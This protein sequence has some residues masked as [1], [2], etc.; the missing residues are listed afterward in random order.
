MFDGRVLKIKEDIILKWRLLVE[1]GR[2]TGHTF[3]QPDL[4]IAA[5]AIHHGLTVVTR[6]RS[7][8]DKAHVPVM[9]P[10]DAQ[11]DATAFPF[12]C[13]LAEPSYR[14]RHQSVKSWGCGGKAPAG[15]ASDP[16]FLLKYG[17]PLIMHN[18]DFLCSLAGR[19]QLSG[20][21]LPSPSAQRCYPA[22]HRQH[23]KRRAA[24]ISLRP[25][26]K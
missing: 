18:P 22:S 20:A 24:R 26:A 25:A 5:T 7:D 15:C 13:L 9:N 1:D 8:Y 16:T 4:M 21:S 19:R 3:S 10:W 12:R 6:D 17:R 2:K 14:E 11:G 23:Q